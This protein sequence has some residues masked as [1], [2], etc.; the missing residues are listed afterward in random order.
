MVSA[1]MNGVALQAAGIIGTWNTDVGAGLS[2]L[3]QGAATLLAGNAKLAEQPISLE[4]A[5]ACIHPEDRDWVFARIRHA[6]ATGG[7]I[8]AEFRIL[9]GS[10]EVRWILSRGYLERD[11]AGVMRGYGIYIDTTATHPAASASPVTASEDDD[12]IHQAA[13]YG[14]RAHAA[15][16]R[17]GDPYLNVL[18]NALLVGIG[19]ALA[20]KSKS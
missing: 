15:I 19:Y 2:R 10:G 6:R 1:T 14:L 4:V 18:A 20:R 17:S 12:P 11:A 16:R 3:D 7:S 5:M 13:E 8:A 9:A